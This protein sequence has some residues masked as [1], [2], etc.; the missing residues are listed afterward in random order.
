MRLNP[1]PRSLVTGVVLCGGRARRMGGADKGLALLHGQPMIAH[2]LERF[3]PQVDQVLVNAN[4]SLD[5]Y[6]AFGPEV[7]E[8]DIDGFPGP[9]AGV[10]CGLARATHGL[11]ATVPCD[12]PGLPADLVARLLEALLRHD[13]TAAVASSGGSP[14]PVFALYRRAVLPTLDKFLAAGGRK[15]D[16]WHTELGAVHVAFDGVEDAFANINTPE[17]LARA[18]RAP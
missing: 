1:T 3:T 10:R 4:R 14:Q 7:I 9:L 8:D 12:A 15:V 6:R 13:V 5:A 2:V 16:Q 11:V 17:D 18:E